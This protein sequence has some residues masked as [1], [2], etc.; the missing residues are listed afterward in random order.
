MAIVDR[1]ATKIRATK[2]TTTSIT[3]TRTTL[4]LVVIIAKDLV[5]T[6]TVTA[7]DVVSIIIATTTTRI[8]AI[9]EF[10]SKISVI[11][12]IT[13]IIIKIIAR[14]ITPT[15]RGMITFYWVSISHTFLTSSHRMNISKKSKM[16]CDERTN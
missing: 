12:A 3:L 2:A 10:P 9:Q 7:R 4:I 8:P 14:R 6:T 5:V 15:V 13:K 1:W 11:T 16:L